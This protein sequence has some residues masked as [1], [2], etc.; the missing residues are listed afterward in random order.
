MANQPGKQ[1]QTAAGQPSHDQ[2]LASAWRQLDDLE[3]EDDL[4][5]ENL[6]DQESSFQLVT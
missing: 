5:N 2:G 6:L 4:L 1:M 3:F